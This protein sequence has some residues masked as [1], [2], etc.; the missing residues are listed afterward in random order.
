MIRLLYAVSHEEAV[1]AAELSAGGFAGVERSGV[2]FSTPAFEPLYRIVPA[3]QPGTSPV[4]AGHDLHEQAEAH[5]DVQILQA[6]GGAFVSPRELWQVLEAANHRRVKIAW[7]AAL[8]REAGRRAALVVPTLNLRLGLVRIDREDDEALAYARRLAGIG[9]GGFI[10][11]DPPAGEAEG[12][13]ATAQKIAATI[14][15]AIAP[16]KPAKPAAVAKPKA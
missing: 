6:N 8:G 12:R 13:F 14:T 11:I 3:R 2:G 7:D 15:A 1:D 9:F 4:D 5:H 16:R 10:V